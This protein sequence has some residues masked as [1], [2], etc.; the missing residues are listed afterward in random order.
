MLYLKYNGNKE[1]ISCCQV[2]QEQALKV[3]CKSIELQIYSN[4]CI[5]AIQTCVYLYPSEFINVYDDIVI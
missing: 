3:L 1:F 5:L 2:L 4:K